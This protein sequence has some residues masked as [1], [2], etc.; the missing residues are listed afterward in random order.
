MEPRKME[1]FLSTLASV[2]VTIL[3]LL[4][5]S[6][7]AYA[8]FF[9]QQAAKFDDLIAEDKVV[10]R[11]R[12]MTLRTHW[13]GSLGFFLNPEFRDNYR[14]RLGGTAG[15]AF[16]NRA[17]TD[18]V[19]NGKEMQEAL[20]EVRTAETMPGPEKGRVYLWA[21]N[22]AISFLTRGVDQAQSKVDVYPANAGAP[23]FEEWRQDFEAVGQA[24]GILGVMKDSMLQDFGQFLAIR[25]ET[26]R[27]SLGPFAQTSVTNALTDVESIRATLKDI[28]KQSLLKRPYSFFERTHGKWILVLVSLAFITGVVV[29]VALLATNI[30]QSNVAGISLLVAT[31]ALSIGSVA[32]FGWDVLHK[33]EPKKENYVIARWQADLLQ[34]LKDGNARLNQ[35]DLLGRDEFLDAKSSREAASFPETVRNAL[36][37]YSAA[38]ETYNQ[39]ALA[40]SL[41]IC[42]AMRSDPKLSPRLS[43]PATQTWSSSVTLSPLQILDLEAVD[44]AL[45]SVKQNAQQGISF[46][47]RR[48][49]WSR[50]V[51]V[52]RPSLTP[53]E[54]ADLAARFREI[55]KKFEVDPTK[56]DLDSAR[57]QTSASSRALEAA[58]EGWK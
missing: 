4:A 7:A 16:V 43:P 32:L 40:L 53:T 3:T 13:N 2:S 17:A 25:P 10:V 27:N 24:V 56:R 29:P 31:L 9:S 48:A 50:V 41:K 6:Y 23:G 52:I 49:T 35:G 5:A 15:A 57:H 39:V 14:H 28:D 54:N 11:D 42:E 45:A 58:L 44:K 55:A 37:Q 47:I 19:F 20:A 22:E 30:N 38:T 51:F 33:P 1:A 18:V 46:E 36:D 34:K 8:V 12:L 26:Q 21:L